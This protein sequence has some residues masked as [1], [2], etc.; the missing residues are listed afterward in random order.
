MKLLVEF[1]FPFWLPVFFL[2]TSK[3]KLGEGIDLG[4]A[5]TPFHLVFLMRWD[6]NPQT[7]IIKSIYIQC[8]QIVDN[9]FLKRL[10]SFSLD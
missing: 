3:P 2:F 4:M 7:F 10:E 6:S 5:L 9:Y 1:V 8:T